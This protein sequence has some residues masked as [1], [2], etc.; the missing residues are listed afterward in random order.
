LI[1]YFSLK[2]KKLAQRLKGL[3]V[4]LDRVDQLKNK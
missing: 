4:R 1:G 3:E 2:N